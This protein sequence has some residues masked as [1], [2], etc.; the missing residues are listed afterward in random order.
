[1][2]KV[3]FFYLFASLFSN[4]LYAKDLKDIKSNNAKISY[5]IENFKIN[6]SFHFFNSQTNEDFRKDDSLTG[7]MQGMGTVNFSYSKKYNDKNEVYSLFEIRKK[8]DNATRLRSLV[9]IKS[10]KYG[11]LSVS[12]YNPIF[13]NFIT[14][15]NITVNSSGAWLRNVNTSLNNVPNSWVLNDIDSVLGFFSD[16]DLTSINYS[17]PEIKGISL[18]AS[19]TNDTRYKKKVALNFPY[20][21]VISL[22]GKI[23]QNITNDFSITASVMSEIGRSYKRDLNNDGNINDDPILSELR[24]FLISGMI[25]YKKFKLVG[26]TGNYYKTNNLNFIPVLNDNT[27]VT[28][29]DSSFFTIAASYKFSDKLNSS[30]Y[31]FYSETGQSYA[32]IGNNPVDTEGKAGKMKFNSTSIAASYDIYQ[33]KLSPYIELSRY[34]VKDNDAIINEQRSK[35]NNGFVFLIGLRSKF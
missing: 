11:N 23:K 16:Y 27:H 7:L 15:Y 29:K 3:L 32:S 25:E 17:S 34:T 31:H 33:D 5:N 35:D 1:M 4:T 18:Y 20:K 14:P 8:Y 9:G 22:V 26:M 19:Y 28:P 10:E 21:D 30:I 24:S 13:D 6:G 12:S 2:K